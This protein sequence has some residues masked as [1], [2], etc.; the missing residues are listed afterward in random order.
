MMA[1]GRPDGNILIGTRAAAYIP[2]AF[3]QLGGCSA[4]CVVQQGNG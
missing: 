4:K 3:V 1:P 2:I